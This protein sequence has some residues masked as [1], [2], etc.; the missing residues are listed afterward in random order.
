MSEVRYCLKV[1]GSI[2]YVV[3]CFILKMEWDIV[4][5]KKNCSRLV[6]Y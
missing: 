1:V 2:K 3:F 5:F 4:V 6:L